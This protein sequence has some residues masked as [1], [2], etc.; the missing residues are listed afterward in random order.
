MEGN[1]IGDNITMHYMYSVA[2]TVAP[3]IAGWN[4]MVGSLTILPEVA[5][6]TTVVIY[7]EHACIGNDILLDNLKILPR[8]QGCDDLV[9]NGGFS[10]G[11]MWYFTNY[12]GTQINIVS[13]KNPDNTTNYAVWPY[14][15]KLCTVL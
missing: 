2:T 15:C 13:I 14:N 8:T 9:L 5:N 12:G 11:D 1:N 4:T 6:A 10:S 7:T 3:A